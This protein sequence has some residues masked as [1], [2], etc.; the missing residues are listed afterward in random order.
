MSVSC[1]TKL[2]ESYEGWSLPIWAKF[3]RAA[4][5]QNWLSMKLNL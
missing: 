1:L 3:H 4:K 5:H 2:V